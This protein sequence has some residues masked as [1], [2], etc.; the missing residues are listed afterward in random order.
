MR[1]AK[2]RPIPD[3]L[4]ALEKPDLAHPGTVAHLRLRLDDVKEAP[5][6]VTLGVWPSEQLAVL[7][8]DAN[9]PLTP[10]NVP[11]LSMKSL[12]PHDSAIVMSWKEQSLAPGEK[13]EVGFE[14]GVGSL[15]G[16]GGR[17]GV[18]VDGVFRP[19]G[20][21]TVVAYVNEEGDDSVTLTL[22]DG[23]KLLEGTATQSVPPPARAAKSGS[24]P[25]TWQVQAGPT[26][27]YEFT[28]KTG[29]G[30]SQTVPAEIK[31]AIFD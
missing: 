29:A 11:V 16:Q 1:E 4:Q 26:G 25:V 21:L 9:G 22:P 5:I 27:K 31:G 15:A 24:R 13:R 18:T 23:F 30:V 19:D 12:D 7:D 2:D 6:R 28:V 8:R 3:F 14:Y 17:L 10:W 20:H